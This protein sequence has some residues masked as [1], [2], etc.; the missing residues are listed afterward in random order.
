MKWLSFILFPILF[1]FNKTTADV[2]M[3]N[4]RGSNN[5]CDERANDRNNANRLFDS[6]NNGAGGYAAPCQDTDLACFDMNYYTGSYLDLRYTT[7]HACGLQNQCEI[8]IQYGCDTAVRNGEPT[9]AL[10][11]TCT[12]T[13]PDLYNN[14]T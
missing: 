7:Q 4:P 3:H 6:Q 10:G 13:M 11:N 14:D 12:R 1:V 9:S 2:Y 8:I 5:R